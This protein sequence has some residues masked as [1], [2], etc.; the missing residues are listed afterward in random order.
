M[1]QVTLDFD[2][3]IQCGLHHWSDST[4][5]GSSLLDPL[6]ILSG[7]PQILLVQL[8]CLQGALRRLMPTQACIHWT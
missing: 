4:L 2:L 5:V 1:N 6:V 8:S 7:V 3:D